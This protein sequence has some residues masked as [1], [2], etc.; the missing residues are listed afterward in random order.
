MLPPKHSPAEGKGAAAASPASPKN[1]GSS[2]AAAALAP[3]GRPAAAAETIPQAPAQSPALPAASGNQ[4]AAHKAQEPAPLS[5]PH[6]PPSCA[7]LAP[8]DPADLD[9]VVTRTTPV[10]QARRLK[11]TAKPPQGTQ[12]TQVA[13]VRENT[14]CPRAPSAG[15]QKKELSLSTCCCLQI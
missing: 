5:Q 13:Q 14:N 10:T 9:T 2:P 1:W 11:P 3:P 8:R 12:E 4:G 7:V 6:L 15:K